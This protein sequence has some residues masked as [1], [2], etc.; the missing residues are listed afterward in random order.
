MGFRYCA[1]SDYL[2]GNCHR[3]ASGHQTNC[4]LP[5]RGKSFQTLQSCCVAKDSL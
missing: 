3:P 5:V 2:K 4:T 1:D